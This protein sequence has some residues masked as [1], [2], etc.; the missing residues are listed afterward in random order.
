MNISEAQYRLAIAAVLLT[1]FTIGGV[2][3][4]RADRARGA[5]D[6][7]RKD[8]TFEVYIRLL[9]LPAF[10]SLL[11]YLVQPNWVAWSR[12]EFPEWVRVSAIAV[13]AST[14][15]LLF[16]MFRTLGNNITSFSTV[17]EEHELVTTGPYRWIRHPLYT[18]GLSMWMCV[19]IAAANW[20]FILT[21]AL[22]CIMLNF[23]T[24]IEE[25]ELVSRY[26]DLYS[27][28]MQSTGRYWPRLTH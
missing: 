28:Y 13:A 11:V 10:A 14:L 4:S 24:H 25:R 20:F 6:A 22:L 12:I 8:V 2:Y 5:E 23:R 18:F 9:A 1:A 19:G 26:G 27:D 16:W 21:V 3:R 7:S 15:P 17:R